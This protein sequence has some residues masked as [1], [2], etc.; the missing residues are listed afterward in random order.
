M[1]NVTIGHIIENFVQVTLND[2][3]SVTWSQ[4]TLLDWANQGERKIVSLAPQANPVIEPVQ[5][6]AGVK[7]AITSGGI[8]FINAVR[9]LGAGGTT[10]GR[11][12]GGC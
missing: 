7:Q 2:T 10:P 5:L 4:E 6:I 3:L 12:P 1:A 9:N 8:T 11:N